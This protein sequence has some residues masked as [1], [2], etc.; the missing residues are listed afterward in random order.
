V[1]PFFFVHGVPYTELSSARCFYTESWRLSNVC[2]YDLLLVPVSVF[3]VLD[4][5]H[6]VLFHVE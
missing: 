4:G 3:V 6:R 5:G 1:L 2:V